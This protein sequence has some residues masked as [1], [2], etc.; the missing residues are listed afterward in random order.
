ML[1]FF[2]CF[3]DQSMETPSSQTSIADCV[4]GMSQKLKDQLLM[5]FQLA[6]FTTIHDK[7]FKL[8]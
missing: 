7:L 5:K 3:L 6:H 1:F 8:Y 2:F 4:R